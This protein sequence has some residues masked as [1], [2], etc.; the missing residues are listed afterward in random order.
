V[1]FCA[2]TSR[3]AGLPTASDLLWDLKRSYYCADENQDVK[4]HDI[5]NKQI[6]SRIQQFMNSRNHSALGSAYEYSFYSTFFSEKTT[7]GSSA[8]SEM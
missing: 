4:S 5:N 8:I 2:G 1:F 3:P 7:R 6:K